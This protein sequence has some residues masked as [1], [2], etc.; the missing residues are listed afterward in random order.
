MY[1]WLQK[2]FC[3]KSSICLLLLL[4]L[5]SDKFSPIRHNLKLTV[6][7][8]SISEIWFN[9]LKEHGPRF[10]A[11]S[12]VTTQSCCC[13]VNLFLLLSRVIG[14]PC[15]ALVL[16][17]SIYLD[18]ATR[19]Y[20]HEEDASERPLLSPSRDIEWDVMHILSSLASAN[21]SL[22]ALSL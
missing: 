17:E 14:I 8:H 20:I 13:R 12:Q 16:I 7:C 6:R 1:T 19:R 2:W 22:K 18:F 3:I 10:H 4:W 5:I 9:L 15:T 21:T 11:F